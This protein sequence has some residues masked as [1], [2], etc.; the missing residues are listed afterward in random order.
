MIMDKASR[1]VLA[2]FKRWLNSLSL[3][4]S[5]A[6]SDR[7]ARDR[8]DLAACVWAK[9]C[10]IF[11]AFPNKTAI[12]IW[13]NSFWIAAS[14]EVL[15]KS[16]IWM[17]ATSGRSEIA[18]WANRS[19]LL[20]VVSTTCMQPPARATD[21]EEAI[22]PIYASCDMGRTMPVVPNMEMPPMMP[23]LA[24]RVFSARSFPWGAKTSTHTESILS[25]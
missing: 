22:V 13:V 8:S 20:P 21:R 15:K 17:K 6:H 4:N 7:T 23:S 9:P 18:D 2:R 12:V 5:I 1:A 25:T 24:F 16:P 10:A 14:K 11:S 3:V 19:L